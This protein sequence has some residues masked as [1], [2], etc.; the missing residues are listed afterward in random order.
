MMSL[1]PRGPFGWLILVL[2]TSVAAAAAAAQP[3]PA[4][5]PAALIVDMAQILQEAKAGKEVQ[6]TINQQYAT[7]SKE[8]AQQE[9][10]LQKGGAELERQ[11]TVLAP[12]VYNTRAREL[13]QR[14]DTLGKSVQAKRQALQQSLNEAMDKVKNGALEVI[15]DIVKERKADLVLQKQA[16]VFEAEGMD[17]TAEAVTRLDKK[18]PSVPVNLPKPEDG[19][20]R[21]PPKQ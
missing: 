2:A 9:E 7:Y 14:Y 11:R 20:L 21:A 18:L 16:V 3:Q 17:V 8:V 6:S 19:G 12:D 15:A 4:R 10:E 1:A 5:L 13:Q